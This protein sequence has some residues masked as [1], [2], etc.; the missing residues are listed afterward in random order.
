MSLE[1]CAEDTR[2]AQQEELHIEQQLKELERKKNE[3][4]D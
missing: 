3:E 1:E 4:T 2:H